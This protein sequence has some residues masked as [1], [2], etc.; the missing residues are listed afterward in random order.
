MHAFS[1]HTVSISL[2]YELV[3]ALEGSAE[4]GVGMIV[5]CEVVFWA[6]DQSCTPS[7]QTCCAS[8]NDAILPVRSHRSAE[9]SNCGSII[10]RQ[11]RRWYKGRAAVE[12]A[13]QWT[14]SNA[15]QC[16]DHSC[17]VHRPCTE[18]ARTSVS[19]I[20][21]D[22]YMKRFIMS[23][24]KQQP[25]VFAWYIPSYGNMASFHLVRVLQ[26]CTY[27]TLKIMLTAGDVRAPDGLWCG[28]SASN[29]WFK[30]VH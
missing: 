15:L 22:I 3:A 8:D 12:G 30:A 14:G 25:D 20:T 23:L 29:S 17:F 7:S 4:R 27:G 10:S 6:D 2:I 5:L 24:D 16:T 1:L 9:K 26:G 13:G 11:K 28:H 21:L 18:C 19:I